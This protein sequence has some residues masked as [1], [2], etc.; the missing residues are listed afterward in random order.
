MR[1]FVHDYHEK[2]EEEQVFPRFKKAGR[3]VELITSCRPSMAPAASSPRGSSISRPRAPSRPS[4]QQM[5]DAM[6][7]TIVLYR[8]HVA[9]E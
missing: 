4:A 2:N 9:R 3:M 7:A 5:I 1:D 8:P 6:Q